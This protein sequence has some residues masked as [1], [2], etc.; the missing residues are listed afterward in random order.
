MRCKQQ[1][2]LQLADSVLTLKLCQFSG[3]TFI[4]TLSLSVVKFLFK[5]L[6]S[7]TPPLFFS[8]HLLGFIDN[9]HRL[10]RVVQRVAQLATRGESEAQIKY[11][12]IGNSR[13]F[14]YYFVSSRT[15]Q[16]ASPHAPRKIALA[17]VIV[18]IFR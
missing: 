11:I 8:F 10:P 13:V 12:Q 16:L 1:E 7:V 5:E 14:P 6:R 3:T 2:K 18:R 4:S 17:S 15:R 9:F